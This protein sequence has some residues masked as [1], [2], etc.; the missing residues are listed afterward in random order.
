MEDPGWSGIWPK[1]V[2]GAI[3][4]LGLARGRRT[5]GIE[6]LRAVF[7]SYPAAVVLIGIP[8]AFVAPRRQST[9]TTAICLGAVLAVGVVGIVAAVMF[10][11]RRLDVSS[12]ATLADTYRSNFFA[13]L[14]FADCVVVVAFTLTFLSGNSVVYL[15]GVAIALAVF[16][17]AAPTRT[18]VIRRQD[19]LRVA[20]N[21]LDLLQ[22]LETE[23]WNRRG[24]RR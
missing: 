10:R 3:P 12:P 19:E 14:A 6:G 22:V 23:P 9:E 17:V 13:K 8:L 15:V 21:R 5:L 24:F 7:V 4:T 20:G 2:L 11:R 18:D 16:A 1:A